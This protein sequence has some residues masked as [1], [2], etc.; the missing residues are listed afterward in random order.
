MGTVH[1]GPFL[2]PIEFNTIPLTLIYVSSN[3]N[4]LSARSGVVVST[5]APQQ[6][7]FLCESWL[8]PFCWEF[9]CSA[10]GFSPGIPLSSR[11][12]HERAQLF[13]LFVFVLTCGGLVTCSG[14]T[15]RLIA[16]GLR[17]RPPATPNF[18][19]MLCPECAQGDSGEENSPSTGRNIQQNQT[20]EGWPSALTC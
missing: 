10:Y 7:V 19:S 12:E 6:R 5:V 8:G 18:D 20:Q 2:I 14:C 3:R 15:P 16:A 17:F 9:A 4:K 1:A 11:S 13:V